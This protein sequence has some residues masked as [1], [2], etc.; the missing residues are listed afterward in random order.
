M[1]NKH[2]Y[3]SCTSLLKQTYKGQHLKEWTSDEPMSVDY[4]TIEIVDKII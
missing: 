4:K 2:Y 1:W 3:I